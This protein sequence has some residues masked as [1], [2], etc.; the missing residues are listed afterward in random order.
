MAKKAGRIG[1][2][3]YE[4]E[5]EQLEIELVRLQEWIKAEGL[6]VVVVFEGRDSAG[7]G[8]TIKRITRRLNPRTVKVVA[9]PAPTEREKTQLYLQRY[10]AHMPA[11]GEMV[12]FDRSWYNRLG[13]ERVMGFCTD[14]EYE[15]FL[16]LCPVFERSLVNEGIILIKYWLHITDETQEQRFR[17]R[18]TDPRRQWKLSP[19]DVASWNKWVDYSRARDAIFEH[20]DTEW[21]PWFVVD[22]NVKRHARLNVIRHL[23][24]QIDY[25]TIERPVI[26]FP[27]RPDVGDYVA[28]STD[29]YTTIPDHYG[30]SLDPHD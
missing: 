4:R 28:P 11:A 14:E 9:L 20:T 8:G 10:I 6:R 2:K 17:A 13:V 26:D 29:R 18:A 30:A 15:K 7:K 21:A 19:M 5:L 3:E 12:L 27:E 16:E 25:Q 24:D 22:A 1:R 23:L